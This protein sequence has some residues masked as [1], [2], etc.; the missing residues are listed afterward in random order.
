MRRTT[1][2]RLAAL[3]TIA[4]L[5]AGLTPAAAGTD[6]GNRDGALVIGTLVPETG[7]LSEL[8]ESLRVPVEI[9]VTE[10]NAAG[11]VNAQ[12]VTLV[13]G[14]EGED[15]ATA[16]ASLEAL[17]TTNRVDAVIGPASSVTAVG[18]R[19]AP[20]RSRPSCPGSAR[21]PETSSWQSARRSTRRS[22]CAWRP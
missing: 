13:T 5:G 15:P 4:G 9:A 18:L 8:A 3:A 11:G 16:K 2:L 20:T 14:D 19:P 12:P 6:R 21:L 7:K 22:S 10:V 1:G 17:L